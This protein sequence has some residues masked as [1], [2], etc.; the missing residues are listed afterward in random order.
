[1]ETSEPF[2]YYFLNKTRTAQEQ[3]FI[4]FHFREKAKKTLKNTIKAICSNPIYLSD[5][6]SRAEKSRNLEI[7][8]IKVNRG[9]DVAGAAEIL[10]VLQRRLIFTLNDG[11]TR[12]AEVI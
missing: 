5:V 3:R 8:L 10:L 9:S 12:L 7:S 1:M 6:R 4:S 2:C 11:K